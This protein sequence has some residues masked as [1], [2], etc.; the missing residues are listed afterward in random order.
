MKNTQKNKNNRE[1]GG[2]RRC[3]RER[4][5]Q[6]VPTPG[7]EKKTTTHTLHYQLRR[8]YIGTQRGAIRHP[9][10]I[11]TTVSQLTQ[12]DKRLSGQGFVK[13]QAWQR[14]KNVIVEDTPKLQLIINTIGYTTLVLWL[15]I[16]GR[17]GP[18]TSNA[19]TQKSV[20]VFALHQQSKRASASRLKL[21]FTNQL[22]RLLNRNVSYVTT[23]V[24]G[25][26]RLRIIVYTI[27]NGL[28][29]LCNI[30]CSEM[31]ADTQEFWCCQVRGAL[32]WFANLTLA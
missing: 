29:V 26:T 14:T 31:V 32:R 18:I 2:K 3:G 25:S 19:H 8:S 1:G 23:L 6:L 17:A 12:L 21:T 10:Q 24:R 4:G 11:D 15:L 7:H 27:C 28:G 20:P 22:A 30:M 9:M 13:R 5:E 16:D